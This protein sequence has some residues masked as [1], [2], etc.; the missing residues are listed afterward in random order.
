MW[1]LNDFVVAPYDVHESIGGLS[2]IT[3][4]IGRL[5]AT[6]SRS[7]TSIKRDQAGRGDKGLVDGVDA[8]V[9][10]WLQHETV[11]CFCTL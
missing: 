8:L 6:I 1:T 3:I 10:T 5:F 7:L 9:Q 11:G 2:S 4:D